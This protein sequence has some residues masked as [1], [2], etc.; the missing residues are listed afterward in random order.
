MKKVGNKM[1]IVQDFSNAVFLL[2]RIVTSTMMFDL[3]CSLR[4]HGKIL[5]VHHILNSK[6]NG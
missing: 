2:G 4:N 6:K 3:H 5:Y 1:K